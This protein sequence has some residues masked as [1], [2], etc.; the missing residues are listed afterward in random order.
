MAWVSL[1]VTEDDVYLNKEDCGVVPLVNHYTYGPLRYQ[2]TYLLEDYN[3]DLAAQ[4]GVSGHGGFALSYDKL[5]E[6]SN[7]IFG[8]MIITREK[9]L[10]EFN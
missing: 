8:D 9:I 2:K 4:H 6:R 5:L 7:T 3:A 10:S 1:H